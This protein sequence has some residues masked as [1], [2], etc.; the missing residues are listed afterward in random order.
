MREISILLGHIICKLWSFALCSSMTIALCGFSLCL[1]PI[2]PLVPQWATLLRLLERAEIVQWLRCQPY[3]SERDV[4]DKTVVFALNKN[5]RPKQ[6][7]SR[8]SVAVHVRYKSWYISLPSSAKKR[9]M[10]K[11]CVV[12]STW[13]T[14][15][16]FCYISNVSSCPRFNFAVM[17][18]ALRNNGKWRWSIVH[19]RGLT[20]PDN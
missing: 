20:G 9:K 6:Q 8:Y 4:F 3:R 18:L 13:S 11:F 16:Q 17:I 12:Q 19:G 1:S 2:P 5:V 10:I 14:T 15:Q 7:Q